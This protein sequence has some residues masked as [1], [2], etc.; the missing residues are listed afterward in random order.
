MSIDA[1]TITPGVGH[2]LGIP[3]TTDM[4]DMRFPDVPFIKKIKNNDDI[5]YFRRDG[6][7]LYESFS[8]APRGKADRMRGKMWTKEDG[9]VEPLFIPIGDISTPQEI[10]RVYEEL[11]SRRPEII[12]AIKE[13]QDQVAEILT[14]NLSVTERQLYRRVSNQLKRVMKKVQEE[15][16]TQD[17]FHKIADGMRRASLAR[18]SQFAQILGNIS[19][20]DL[21]F[22]IQQAMRDM[23]IEA[24]RTPQ[25]S[26]KKVLVELTP[27]EANRLRA[28]LDGSTPV[29]IGLSAKEKA[30]ITRRRNRQLK[31]VARVG[32]ST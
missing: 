17:D 13:Q 10:R 5:Y 15:S 3:T 24:A 25:A 32:D 22:I 11:E 1:A 6:K 7:T 2:P 4:R 8:T 19:Q 16:L 30:L 29:A 23:G 31:D 12:K 26:D 20:G 21:S 27:E 9:T 14:D 18:R 28:L